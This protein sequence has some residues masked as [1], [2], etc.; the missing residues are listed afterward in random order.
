[1]LQHAGV[2]YE[3]SYCIFI[4]VALTVRSFRAETHVSAKPTDTQ[5]ADTHKLTNGQMKKFHATATHRM[6]RENR[7]RLNGPLRYSGLSS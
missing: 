4:S 1:M 7:P 2:S 6:R 5:I 3:K